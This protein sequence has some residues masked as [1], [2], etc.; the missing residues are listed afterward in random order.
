MNEKS[1]SLM[2][3]LSYPIIFTDSPR[4]PI[5]P[6]V[7]QRLRLASSLQTLCLSDSLKHSILLC[8]SKVKSFSDTPRTFKVRP[9]DMPPRE[10]SWLLRTEL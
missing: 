10:E 8:F 1:R 5:A 4:G 3:E 7:A 2:R 9:V 6:S